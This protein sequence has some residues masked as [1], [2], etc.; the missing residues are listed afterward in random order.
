LVLLAQAEPRVYRLIIVTALDCRSLAPSP[1]SLRAKAAEFLRVAAAAHDPV[2]WRELHLLAESC[3]Q[4]A[5]EI[6]AAAPPAGSALGK[7]GL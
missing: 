4:R 1:A 2:A 3:L 5:R 7:R 6:E